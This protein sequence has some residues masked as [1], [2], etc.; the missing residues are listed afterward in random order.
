[1]VPGDARSHARTAADS[2]V[3]LPSPVEVARSFNALWNERALAAS[4]VAT[5]R[6]VL[7]GF[8]L[9]IAVGVPL[10]LSLDPGV[11]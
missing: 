7:I 1:M 6:R 10:G 4:I 9:A 11:C 8:G 3:I 2:P 5:L